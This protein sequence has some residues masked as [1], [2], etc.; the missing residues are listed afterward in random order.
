MLRETLFKVLAISS[1]QAGTRALKATAGASVP[2]ARFRQKHGKQGGMYTSVSNIISL[3]SQ[4]IRMQR[5]H[6]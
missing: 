5:V 1:V 2:T 6:S 3:K 4:G